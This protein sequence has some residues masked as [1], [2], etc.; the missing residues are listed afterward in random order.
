MP[1]LAEAFI[2]IRGDT[3]QFK[4]DVERGTRGVGEQA[5]AREGA[6]FGKGFT[7]DAANR[8]RDDRGRFSAAGS[9]IG[10]ALGDGLVRDATGR[11]RDGRG[12]F[13]SEGRDAGGGWGRGFRTGAGGSGGFSD[14]ASDLA[15]SL[16]LID[17]AGPAAKLAPLAGAAV[18]AGGALVALAS[19]AGF[20]SA[21][22]AALI[23]AAA[24]AAGIV[25]TVALA[26]SGVAEALKAHAALQ[27]SAATS[28][29]K[30]ARQELSN[31]TAI[32]SAQDR[33][34]DAR[35]AQERAAVDGAE[36]IHDAQRRVADA[37]RGVGDAVRERARV[38]QD[39]AQQVA[40]AERSL[41]DAQQG[42]RDAQ[43]DLNNARA[44]A[45]QKLRDMK[46]QV[47]DAG[48]GEEA[49][50]IRVERAAQRLAEVN[51]SGKATDLDRREAALA[52]KEAQADL[53]DATEKRAQTAKDAAKAEKAG[54]EGSKEVIDAK[55]RQADANRQVSD[56]ERGLART[57]RD[58]AEAQRQASVRVTDA[59]RTLK[60]AERDLGKARRDAARAQEDA[61]VA[62]ARAV[63]GLADAQAK[64]SVATGAANTA[65]LKYQAA[66]AKLT[67]AGRAFVAQ[68]LRMTPLLNQLK[69]T[70][71]DTLLPGLGRGLRDASS[72]FPIVNDAVAKTGT[73]LGQ[74]AADLGAFAKTPLFQAQMRT[75][76]ANN[77][78][79]LQS[80]S[81]TAVPLAGAISAVAAASAPLVARFADA[82][83]HALNLAAAWIQARAQTGQLQDFFQRAGDEMA[84]WGRIFA[85][86]VVTI[87]NIMRGALPS[88]QAMAS[89][90]ETITR[91]MRDW[92]SS[93]EGQDKIK[94]FF[95]FIAHIDY[96]R[97]L[98][99]AAAISALGL[100]AKAL[101]TVGAVTGVIAQLAAGGPIGIAVL[102]IGALA[103]AFGLLWTRSG[104]FRAEVRQLA[105][106]ISQRLTPVVASLTQWWHDRLYPALA[107]F[108]TNIMPGLQAGWRSVTSAI[109]DNRGSLQTLGTWVMALVN[110]FLKYL[111]PIL[112]RLEGFYF[113]QL[114]FAI[115]LVIRG[116]GLFVTAASA[117]WRGI[118]TA[119]SAA[120]NTVLHPVLSAFA[121]TV[122]FLWR[123]VVVPAF[124]GISAVVRFVIA[125]NV[126][127]VLK[128]LVAQLRNSVMPPIMFLW[129]NVF[130]PA[131]NGIASVVGGVW[132]NVIRPTFSAIGT[133]VGA[134]RSAFRAAVDGIGKAWAELREKTAG[135]VRFIVNTVY[136]NGVR[137][138]WNQANDLW[139]GRDLPVVK[140]ATGGVLPMVVNRP[141][142]IVG[143]GNPRHPEYVIPTDPKYRN[144]ARAL[145]AM[146]GAQLMA[147]GGI[148]GKI[149]TLGKL[150]LTEARF[151]VDPAGAIASVLSAPLKQLNRIK[152]NEFGRGV[153]RVPEMTVD[154]LKGLA[155]PVLGSVVSSIFGG[156]AAGSGPVNVSLNRVIAW[157]RNFI[158][159]P[160]SWGAAGPGG[161]DCSGW[162]SALINYAHGAYPFQRLF[163]T[164]N[165]PGGGLVEGLRSAFEVGWT[166]SYRGGPGHTAATINGV[167][168]ESSGGHGVRVGMGS[169]GAFDP[170]FDHHAGLRGFAAG[171][172]LPHDLRRGDPPFDLISRYGRNYLGDP[173]LAM[174]AGLSGGAL[175][176]GLRADSGG[177]LAPGWNPP[178]FNGTGRP[179]LLTPA[180]A[181]I[182]LGPKS[183]AAISAALTVELDGQVLARAQRYQDTRG[184]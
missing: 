44:D 47:R 140:F 6:A 88:G 2:R 181:T 120:W 171:G 157:A 87:F 49:A 66:L 93:V 104:Q 30:S 14:I 170:L 39:S 175:M 42:A 147:D 105:G 65:A 177:Y 108:V 116:L 71:Q 158:G 18:I 149:K 173:T 169:R 165:M 113:K 130:V 13:V 133:A 162:V 182:E 20:A 67:P 77:T 55:R 4:P 73:I 154:H 9:D 155:K 82:A 180:G 134:V 121:A 122:G 10:G 81:T 168:L 127:P 167:P 48:L 80:M 64:N 146:A 102:A 90:I 75:V 183:I 41:R 51:R 100:A 156:G 60:E 8:M 142:A 124:N 160:Y 119:A 166:R 95:Q 7:R 58:A 101:Q 107:A 34:T 56:A 151:T 26:W 28:S 178:I 86:I 141:T 117:A 25:G 99:V 176:A 145:H 123:N 125:G 98:Q 138:L 63:Q 61:A 22:L 111:V 112:G 118:S 174:L 109:G 12:R 35:K 38:A 36:R 27:D 110:A 33:I 59:Q 83:A 115:G 163:A 159:A 84:K 179:E 78:A 70:A 15:K 150:G 161:F 153:A 52:L 144:R 132:R 74:A 184:L 148:V 79:A 91:K 29:G 23:P 103:A 164:A 152:T 46:D 69:A 136:N 24:G 128:A 92:S 85:N 129:R 89:T 32:R 106:E 131:F 1:P 45:I 62:V 114:G 72:L 76:V 5:G 11:L 57:R 96:G 54:V 143:E 126:A 53:A 172:I 50:Q 16:D 40:D 43:V 137:R 3:T 97:I 21:S 139:S 31:A 17:F 94:A 37:E 68:L 135:P 19:S